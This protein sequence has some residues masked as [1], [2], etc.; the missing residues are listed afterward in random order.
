M[1]VS[2]D[3]P[4]LSPD[5]LTDGFLGD[6]VVGYTPGPPYGRRLLTW[7]EHDL[8]GMSRR[9]LRRQ[10]AENLYAVLDQVGVHGQPPTLM[11]SFNGVEGL[12]SSVL[13]APAFWDD[14]ASAVPGELV[15]GVPAR[16]VVMFTG[17]QSQ[18]GLQKLRRAVDRVIFAGGP[19]LLCQDLLV[20]RGRRWEIFHPAMAVEPVSPVIPAQRTPLSS[21]RGR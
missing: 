2:T 5:E 1:L 9:Q 14:L 6:I 4:Q 3:D 7:Q 21:G 13:L 20:R 16:D 12:E 17:S 18:S 15:V 19:H 8:S 10:A 11:I